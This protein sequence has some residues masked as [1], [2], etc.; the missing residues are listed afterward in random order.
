ML[1]K[2]IK[3]TFRKLW[4]I[5]FFVI[6]Q[7]QHILI[8]RRINWEVCEICRPNASVADFISN[9]WLH[10]LR[11]SGEQNCSYYSTVTEMEKKGRK[12]RLCTPLQVIECAGGSDETLAL[13]LPSSH[14]LFILSVS[15]RIV[16]QLR[17]DWLVRSVR[18]G[19][20]IN[21]RCLMQPHMC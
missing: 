21:L 20:P 19:I 7:S 1:I 6:W 12:G 8:P 4:K 10:K 3:P 18:T 5:F 17:S 9:Q 14:S 11:H 16:D 13:T 15:V 2:D